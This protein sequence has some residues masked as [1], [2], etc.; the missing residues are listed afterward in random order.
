M[1]VIW[2]VLALML[3]ESIFLVQNSPF[4]LATLS[5]G[6]YAIMACSLVLAVLVSA[7]SSLK[8]ESSLL[9]KALS[10][11]DPSDHFGMRIT[12]TYNYPFI[13]S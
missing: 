11:T 6:T 12:K 1:K 9:S 7:Y 2:L 5:I 13:K 3:I 10:S 4:N 8:L